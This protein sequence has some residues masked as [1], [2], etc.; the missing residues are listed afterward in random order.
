[1][2]SKQSDPRAGSLRQCSSE[3]QADPATK[4]GVTRRAKNA[5]TEIAMLFT[6]QC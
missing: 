1:M 2:I 6:R 4:V 3:R 5:V